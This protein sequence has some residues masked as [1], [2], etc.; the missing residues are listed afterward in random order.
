M[1]TLIVHLV[2]SA[3]RA[4]VVGIVTVK[5]LL[6]FAGIVDLHQECLSLGRREVFGTKQRLK[7]SLDG[8]DHAPPVG[9]VRLST[10]YSL[11]S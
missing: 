3:P 7:G 2:I 10:M 9:V 1:W 6:V 11:T 5:L 8:I 4:I